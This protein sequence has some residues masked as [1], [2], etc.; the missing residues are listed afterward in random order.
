MGDQVRNWLIYLMPRSVCRW[1]WA[2]ENIPL[3]GWAP[4]VLGRVLGSVPRRHKPKKEGQ[5]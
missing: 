2:H 1:L 5:L 4:F 3:G